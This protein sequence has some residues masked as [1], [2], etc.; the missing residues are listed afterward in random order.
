MK[1]RIENLY[2]ALLIAWNEG[3]QTE[4]L[5]KDIARC[6]WVLKTRYGMRG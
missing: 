4:S 5:A 6:Y 1:T 2:K 3:D